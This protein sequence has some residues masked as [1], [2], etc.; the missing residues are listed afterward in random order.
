[1]ATV[2]ILRE[3]VVQHQ[4]RVPGDVVTVNAYTARQMANE[5]PETFEWAD[6]PVQ[7]FVDVVQPAPVGEDVAKRPVR[8]RKKVDAVAEVDGV[9]A[10]V[11]DADESA[12]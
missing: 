7:Q 4:R 10:E 2:K 11:G 1:M 12:G 5:W 9:D 3:C 6:R 8:G